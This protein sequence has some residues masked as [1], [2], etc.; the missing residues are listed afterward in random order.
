MPSPLDNAKLSV[1]G[2]AARLAI[3]AAKHALADGQ[4]SPE[5]AL[6]GDFP[7]HENGISRTQIIKLLESIPGIGRMTAK[8][9]IETEGVEFDAKVGSLG[10]TTRAAIAVLVKQ[11]RETYLT[12]PP[13][14]PIP[15]VRPEPET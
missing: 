2:T 5:D 7:E 14:E 9:I 4:V 15:Y 11:A 1:R 3:S 10:W 6:N 13:V 12:A 8:E